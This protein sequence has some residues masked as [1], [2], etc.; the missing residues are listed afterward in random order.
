MNPMLICVIAAVSFALIIAGVGAA[1]DKSKMITVRKASQAS[2]Y[3]DGDIALSE[4][5]DMFLR[6]ET[7]EIAPK[8]NM[9]ANGQNGMNGMNGMGNLGNMN[10]MPG[11][12]NMGNQHGMP[13]MH[14]MDSGNGFHGF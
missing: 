3:V 6:S 12:H 1:V 9:N 14:N 2:N 13:G 7:R 10:G 11:M 5:N 4:M 8:N